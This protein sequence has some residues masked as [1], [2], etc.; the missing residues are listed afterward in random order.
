[1][2]HEAAAIAER[3][4][5]AAMPRQLPDLPGIEFNALYEPATSLLVGGDWYDVFHL[6][7]GRI[8]ISVGDV[9]GHGIEAAVVMQR[10][11][12]ALHTA[13]IVN[14]N[15]SNALRAADYILRND[16]MYGSEVDAFCTAS[17]A[18]LDPN[19]MTL[20]VAPAGH[21]GPK[22][23]NPSTGEVI[24]PFTERA[25]PLGLRH[26]CPSDVQQS[27]RLEEESFAAF[28]TDG[29]VEWEYDFLDG[30]RHLEEAISRLEIRNATNPAAAIRNAVIRGVAHDDVAV[31]TC[32]VLRA[33]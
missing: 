32:K 4:Q 28:Y 5:V 16:S 24:D 12:N 27:I 7:D 15:L 20:M 6:P 31:L 8:G 11:K 19:V 9:S 29:L 21:P 14:P 30:E 13:L 2:H 22:I 17:L 26:L 33:P 10:V 18:I 23:W 1:M 3:F 25:L